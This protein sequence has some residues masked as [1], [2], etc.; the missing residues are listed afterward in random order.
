M[1]RHKVISYK[2]Q[3]DPTNTYVAVEIETELQKP[4]KFQLMPDVNYPTVAV[5][6]QKLK[7]A[8]SHCL[9]EYEKVDV[10]VFSE[11]NYVSINVTNFINTRF[12]GKAVK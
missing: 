11:R 2:V 12:T 6:E 4:Y 5:I 7:E 3:T 1:A 9:T 10:S 8:L